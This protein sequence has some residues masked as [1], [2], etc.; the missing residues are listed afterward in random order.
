MRCLWLFSKMF[1]L[2][3]YQIVDNDIG[4]ANDGSHVVSVVDEPTNVYQWNIPFRTSIMA[5]ALLQVF[6]QQ[7]SIRVFWWLH[8]TY[9][10]V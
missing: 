2:H 9:L 6:W 5:Y 7:E 3:F 4:V 8:V 10:I 1:I